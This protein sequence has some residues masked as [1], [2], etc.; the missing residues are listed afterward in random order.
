M[1][2]WSSSLLGNLFI[3]VLITWDLDLARPQGIQCMT[4]AIT[5][6]F[7]KILPT[8]RSNNQSAS[9]SMKH[10]PRE[11]RELRP[12]GARGL[13]ERRTSGEQQTTVSQ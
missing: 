11:Q 2:P 10:L 9:I 8:I 6:P 13:I 3:G 7:D 1:G 4:A 5:G 12:V